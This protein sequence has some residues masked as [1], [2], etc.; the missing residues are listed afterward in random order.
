MCSFFLNI[1]N[2]N[3]I[4]IITNK[5]T[6]NFIFSF[7][8]NLFKNL[9]NKILHQDYIFFIKR[10]ISQIFNTTLNEVNMYSLN[11]VKSLIILF[12][13]ILI[14]FGIL[15]LIILTGNIKGL[16]LIFPII[17]IVSIILKKINQS[18]KNWSVTRIE[19]NEKIINYN[20]NLINGIKEI[21]IFGKANELIN[22]FD[23]SLKSLKDVD[24][25]HNV[26]TAYPKVLL[27]QAVILIFI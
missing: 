26:V 1:F 12:S 8:T 13:E 9:I 10:G 2:K 19:Q 23:N 4:I 17:I 6:Y 25:K 22:K 16:I 21:L 7:R 27:E 24:I 18:I 5:L 3:L 14:S 20:L 15:L 11:I